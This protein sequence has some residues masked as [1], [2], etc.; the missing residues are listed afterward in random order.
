MFLNQKKRLNSSGKL[1]NERPEK[2]E[3]EKYGK[4]REVGGGDQTLH[5]SPLSLTKS[6]QI[7]HILKLCSL[8]HDSCRGLLL[9]P[10]AYSI[11]NLIKKTNTKKIS[12]T[13]SL[14]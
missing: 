12:V 13:I 1:S 8:R 4:I 2:K 5:V 3:E 11:Q 10:Y 14:S 7:Q 6:S 9:K